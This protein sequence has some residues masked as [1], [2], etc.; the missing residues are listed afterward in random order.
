MKIGE[1]D[2]S[3]LINSILFSGMDFKMK[4]NKRMVEVSKTRTYFY[5]RVRHFKFEE[6]AIESEIN[7]I[8]KNK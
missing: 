6:I 8:L 2:Q 4:F 5:L 7:E 1:I 3:R